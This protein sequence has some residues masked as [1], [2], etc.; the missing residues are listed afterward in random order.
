MRLILLKLGSFL[1]LL[2]PDSFLGLFLALRTQA[3]NNC[4]VLAFIIERVQEEFI[5]LEQV[6][7]EVAFKLVS[8]GVSEFTLAVHLSLFECSLVFVTLCPVESPRSVHHI[9]NKSAFVAASICENSCALSMLLV[10]APAAF[11]FSD[12]SVLVSLARVQLESVAMA[13]H[14]D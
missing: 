2:T 12:D 11:V 14:L 6:P 4:L 7:S 1:L 5:L 8:I 9:L 13:N 10:P 3:G